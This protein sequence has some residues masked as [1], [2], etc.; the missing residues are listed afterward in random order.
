MTNNWKQIPGYD[1][2]YEVSDD[3]F[4]RSL[5]DRFGRVRLLTPTL[6]GSEGGVRY[7][8]VHL[9]RSDGGK[10]HPYVHRLMLEVFIGPKPDGMEGRHLNGDSLD[11]RV[12]NLAYGTHG[13]NTTDQVGH[14]T[15]NQARKTHCRNGH[16]YDATNTRIIIRPD[17][18]R[19]RRCRTCDRETQRRY[20]ERRRR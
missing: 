15:H 5:N 8:Q 11:N 16:P 17:G 9:T 20:Y 18:G 6:T 19:E 4:V 13:D 3:G 14:G 12:E 10:A 2:R 7:H 1:G